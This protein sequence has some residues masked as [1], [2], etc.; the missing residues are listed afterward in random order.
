MQEAHLQVLSVSCTLK[1]RADNTTKR[2]NT[3]K[4]SGIRSY[5]HPPHLRQDLLW[6]VESGPI[7]KTHCTQNSRTF[8]ALKKFGKQCYTKASVPVHCKLSMHETSSSIRFP[9][10]LTKDKQIKI[11][12]YSTA[13]LT[14]VKGI[15]E[16]I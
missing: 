1:V 4:A 13:V 12:G 15:Y 2:S 16:N 11:Y 6:P 10:Y 14:L 8:I 3:F 7:C 5:L 9:R